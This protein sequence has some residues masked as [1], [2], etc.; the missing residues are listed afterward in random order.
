[1]RGTVSSDLK[2]GR[3][4]LSLLAR[5][6]FARTPGGKHFMRDL[7]GVKLQGLP[8]LCRAPRLFRTDVS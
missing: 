2:K 4:K 6:A 5:C 8:L 3:S 7:T 1:M